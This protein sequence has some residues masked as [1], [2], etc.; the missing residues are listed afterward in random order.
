M[1]DRDDPTPPTWPTSHV[2]PPMT[3]PRS[4]A[5]AA[6]EAGV[7]AHPGEAPYRALVEAAA[8]AIITIDAAGVIL[9]FNNGAEE[10]FGYPA[11]EV[12]G[13][14]LL[15]LLA[16]RFQPLVTS[17][18]RLF[19]DTGEAH[20]LGR[21]LELAGV[22]KDGTEVPLELIVT[23]LPASDAPIFVAILRDITE[24]K[25]IEAERAALLAAEQE[26][27]RRLRELQALKAD[28]TEMVAHEL[29]A[30]VAAMRVA[31]AML[32]T[33]RLTAE[34]QSQV[35][36]TLEH[37]TAALVAL[38]ADVRTAA[39]A[40]HDDFAARPR[41]VAVRSLLHTAAAFARALPGEHPLTLDLGTDATVLA[42]PDRIGQVLRNLLGNAAK[43]TP[44]G[45]P[46]TLRA[47]PRGQRVRV[48]VADQGPGI[49]PDDLRRIFEKF[50]R[51]RDAT[52]GHV[53]GAGLGLYLSRRLVQAHGSDITVESTPGTGSV[54]A[55][56]LEVAP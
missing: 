47:S 50:G 1:A 2:L 13:Q 48:E 27:A 31:V 30:P 37:E 4:A 32:R 35:V 25:E 49:H 16:A 19:L 52:G 21:P 26:A 3:L 12:L 29:A 51:G 42:D 8:D 23:A 45:T 18:V 46:I 33:G 15:G 20:L 56:E 55:F 6:S 54:F 34:Q 36:G 53:A 11:G 17:G 40:E 5:H 24:R 9:T 39:H 14:R 28:F 44:D 7:T 43:Y 22:R 38:V 10:I 41:P